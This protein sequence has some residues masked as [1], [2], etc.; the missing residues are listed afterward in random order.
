MNRLVGHDR[1]DF[2]KIPASNPAAMV[3]PSSDGLQSRIV[4]RATDHHRSLDLFE[5]KSGTDPFDGLQG[6]GPVIPGT[7]ERRVGLRK[8]LG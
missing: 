6:P 7:D 5:L 2:Q 1:N 3:L 4:H 8:I